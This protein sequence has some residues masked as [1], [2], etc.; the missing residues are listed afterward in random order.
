M[1]EINFRAWDKKL[2]K[3]YTWFALY[4]NWWF[5]YIEDTD[6][7]EEF[8]SIW[9]TFEEIELMQFTSYKDINWINIF[10]WDIVEYYWKE[11]EVFFKNW[12][13]VFWNKNI[14][15]FFQSNNTDFKVIWNI[16]ETNR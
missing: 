12:C 2:N 8:E 10:E 11:L 6:I 5:F 14:W 4:K 7:K 1:K 3:M 16:Y 13:F 15:D 9:K